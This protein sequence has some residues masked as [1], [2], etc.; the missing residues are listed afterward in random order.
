[1]NILDKIN[2]VGNRLSEQN[3]DELS[4]YK[5]S[6]SGPD[7][8]WIIVGSKD[9]GDYRL[10]F[11]FAITERGKSQTLKILLFN[12]CRYDKPICIYQKMV[13]CTSRTIKSAIDKLNAVLGAFKENH[14]ETG[15]YQLDTQELADVLKKAIK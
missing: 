3:W 12:H 8:E 11:S 6:V 15:G 2:D 1:M 4:K 9:V 14:H 10:W 7:I 5:M 13:V